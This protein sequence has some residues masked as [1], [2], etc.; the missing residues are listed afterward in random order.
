MSNQ[1]IDFVSIDI[2]KAYRDGFRPALAERLNP[3]GDLLGPEAN[4]TMNLETRNLTLRGPGV[5]GGRL[6]LKL[7]GY[8]FNSQEHL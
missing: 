6:D 7:S 2:P 4:E 5:Q 1:I 8:V 3:L